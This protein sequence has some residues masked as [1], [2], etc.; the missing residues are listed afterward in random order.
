MPGCLFVLAGPCGSY[1]A[2]FPE[3]F[4]KDRIYGDWNYSV[5]SDRNIKSI[6]A[7]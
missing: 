3:L 6:A 2:I 4:G 5:A 7:E 1:A